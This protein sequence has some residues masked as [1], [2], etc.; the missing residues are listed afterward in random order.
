MLWQT[1][2]DSTYAHFTVNGTEFQ[3]IDKTRYPDPTV[4]DLHGVRASVLR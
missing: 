4:S 2:D 3:K 1:Q